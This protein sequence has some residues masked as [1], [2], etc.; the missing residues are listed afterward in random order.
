MSDY[1]NAVVRDFGY[2]SKD[3]N[4]GTCEEMISNRVPNLLDI[5]GPSA[6]IHM[7]CSS[8]LIATHPGCQSLQSGESEMAIFGG[9]GMIIS[10]DGNMQLNNL[11]FRNPKINPIRSCQP[12]A[13]QFSSCL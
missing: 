3:H 9:V 13:A 8:N 12:S 10:L 1:R 5:H 2:S 4:L 6:T 11:R 7:A